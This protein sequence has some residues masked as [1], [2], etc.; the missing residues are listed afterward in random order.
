MKIAITLALVKIKLE[1]I[2]SIDLSKGK[3]KS[4]TTIRIKDY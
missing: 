3:G 2:K 1:I 4:I